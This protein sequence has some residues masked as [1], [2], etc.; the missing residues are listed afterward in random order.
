MGESDLYVTRE[1][2]IVY[3]M[4]QRQLYAKVSTLYLPAARGTLCFLKI[5]TDESC[6]VSEGYQTI[7][8]RLL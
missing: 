3:V 5:I 8:P 2:N 1:E 4:N 7:G 6:A